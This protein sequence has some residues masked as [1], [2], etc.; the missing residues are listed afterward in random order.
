MKAPITPKVEEKL[1]E[2]MKATVRLDQRP[3]AIPTSA[4]FVS[5]HLK[6]IREAAALG[7]SASEIARHMGVSVSTVA[8]V[9]FANNIPVKKKYYRGANR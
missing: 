4:S 9:A 3:R 6:Q 8:R 5:P 7:F 1:G 2:L